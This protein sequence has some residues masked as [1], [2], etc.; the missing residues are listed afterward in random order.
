MYR[1]GPWPSSHVPGTALPRKRECEFG[2]TAFATKA[3]KSSAQIPKR[4]GRAGPYFQH[5]EVIR[6]KGLGRD[7]PQ[8]QPP[9]KTPSFTEATWST[10][11]HLWWRGEA[12]V[13]KKLFA[14]GYKVSHAQCFYLITLRSTVYSDYFLFISRNFFPFFLMATPAAYGSFRARD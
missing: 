9:P 2:G 7:Y 4:A 13:G 6:G 11:I 14:L 8:R 12:W 3:K 10:R 1:H 5:Q